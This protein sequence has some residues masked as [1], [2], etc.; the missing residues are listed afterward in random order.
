MELS[1][2]AAFVKVVQAGSFT[3]A[4]RLLEAPKSTVS[5]KVAALEKRLGV[6]LLHRTTRQLRMTEDGESFFKACSQALADISAAEASISSKQET[7]KGRLVVT[8]PVDFGGVLAIFLRSF[9][10]KYPGIN[11]EL[12]LSNRFVDLV[13]ENVD[14]AIR[15][16]H[17][18]DS[19]LVAKRL[20]SM[21]SGIFAAPSYLKTFGEPKHPKDLEKHACI[22]FTGKDEWHLENK[23]KAISIK[24]DGRTMVDQ[25]PAIK[26]LV[27]NGL[28]ISL[29][30]TFF[31]REDV[32]KGRLVPVL[33]DWFEAPTP[34]SI[35]YPA[36]KFQHPKTKVFI[37]ECAE[38]IKKYYE[39]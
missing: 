17:L 16:G 33:T 38:V 11:V 1:D 9:L 2:V 13:G 27:V 21:K 26:D 8:G 18:K 20:G 6:T 7:P 29:L 34:I 3:Q 24:V 10:D 15:A 12:I 39:F 19:S 23:G 14:I 22:R 32:A 37:L 35:V 28:G 30:P 31:C 25:L 5:A 4:A 36:E